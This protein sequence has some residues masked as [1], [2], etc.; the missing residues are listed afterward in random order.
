MTKIESKKP[1]IRVGERGEN[2]WRE[3]SWDEALDL[4]ASKMLE[5]KQKYGPESFVF[6]CKSS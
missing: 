5:I 6:T 3:A 1:L 4:V 2:K